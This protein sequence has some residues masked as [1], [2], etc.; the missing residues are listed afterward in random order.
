[1]RLKHSK[2]PLKKKLEYRMLR[3]DP[4]DEMGDK[5]NFEGWYIDYES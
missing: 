4:V 1:M 2:F 3:P 5:K